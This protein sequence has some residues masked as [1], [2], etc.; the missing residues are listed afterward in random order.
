MGLIYYPRLQSSSKTTQRKRGKE[1]NIYPDQHIG[2]PPAPADW[3]MAV[4]LEGLG[5]GTFYFAEIRRS[6]DPV[7]RLVITGTLLEE[8][9]VLLA[10]KV[11]LW[12]AEYLV[13]TQVAQ[14]R[15]ASWSS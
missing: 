11:R 15:S 8:A 5:E 12:I 3:T 6:G 1:M 14:Q 10:V 7:C 9:R 13:T 4:G 2:G